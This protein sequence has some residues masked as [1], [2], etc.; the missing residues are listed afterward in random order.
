MGHGQQLTERE[1]RNITTYRNENKSLRWI[2]KKIERSYTV[3]RNFCLDIENY[4]NKFGSGRAS[5]LTARD[6]RVLINT[7]SKGKSSSKQL[8]KAWISTLAIELSVENFKDATFFNTKNKFNPQNSLAYT[9][10]KDCSGLKGWW[11]MVVDGTLLSS[12]MKR[13]SI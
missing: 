1:K 4:G 13:N 8:K 2:A 7:A 12:L 5:K 3:V 10:Q 11:N 6:R 9:K